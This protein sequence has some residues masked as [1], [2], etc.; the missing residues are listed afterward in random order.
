ME[1]L[2]V[3]DLCKTYPG[4]TLDHVSFSLESGYIMGFIGRNGA[5]KTTTLKSMLGLVHPDGGT[6]EMFGMDLREN[7]SACRQ[8]I[9]VV[10]CDAR[11]YAS[12][13]LRDVA[14]R[15]ARFYEHWD[16]AAYREYMK[17]FSLDETK[18]VRE[19]STGMWVKFT[20]ALALSHGARLLLLDEPTSGLDPVSR[21]ELLDI[22]RDTVANGE[23][24]ILFSTHIISD[25]EKCADLITYIHNGK[26]LGLVPKTHIPN[27]GEFYERRWFAS[28][29]D[30][31]FLDCTMEFAGQ[32]VVGLSPYQIFS[33]NMPN[34]V[35]GVEICED[36]WTPNPPSV[37][38][39]MHGAT[40]IV[41]LSASDEINGKDSYRRDLVK[42]QSGRLV[43]GY[44]YASAGEGESSTDL[45]F[46]GHHLIAEN[47]SVLAESERFTNE[48]I[49]GDLDMERLIGEIR[50]YTTYDVSAAPDGY[51][52]VEY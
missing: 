24:S 40:V 11:Y 17:R 42:L 38:H 41:N 6:V 39:A 49:Y 44:I 15:T 2:S 9:G 46:G 35:L 19:L 23:S 26:I 16:D 14:E 10:L 5:G 13:R 45:V 4:F 48:T 51:I 21:D 20:L 28:A 30:S 50:H 3:R 32:E 52:E 27:Y 47:G 29:A 34:L 8:Q 43:C 18:R 7:E 12:K 22:F 33:C 37:R 1:L 31:S 36:L 25:L